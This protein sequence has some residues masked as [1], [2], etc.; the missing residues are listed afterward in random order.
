MAAAWRGLHLLLVRQSW[1]NPV[2]IHPQTLKSLLHPLETQ[3]GVTTTAC[4]L[5]TWVSKQMESEKTWLRARA[6]DVSIINPGDHHHGMCAT[7]NNTPVTQCIW[8]LVLLPRND[9][10]TRPRKLPFIKELRHV[11]ALMD[12]QGVGFWTWSRPLL[13]SAGRSGAELILFFLGGQGYSHARNH[14]C[15]WK[16]RS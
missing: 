13:S 8:K 10:W 2:D 1:L 9:V 16:T 6:A 4:I 15:H 7:V 5:F 11:P 3:A 14:C 12:Q